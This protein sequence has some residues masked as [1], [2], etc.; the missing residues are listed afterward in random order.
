MMNAC[1]LFYNELYKYLKIIFTKQTVNLDFLYYIL[2]SF[3]NSFSFLF[4][5]HFSEVF[6]SPST[7]SV[8]C[9]WQNRL[10]FLF[11]YSSIIHKCSENNNYDFSIPSKQYL[12][13]E[14]VCMIAV[15]NI[16]LLWIRWMIAPVRTFVSSIRIAVWYLVAL[17]RYDF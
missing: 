12:S 8:A 4:I 1:F 2:F 14:G 17:K 7:I 5:T 15:V 6:N 13:V 3:S 11:Q 10:F 16:T 9:I